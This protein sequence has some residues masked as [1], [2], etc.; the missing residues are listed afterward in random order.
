MDEE[1][2]AKNAIRWAMA[3][4]GSTAYATRCLAFV[5]DAIERS[6]EIEMFGGDDAAESARIYDAAA[7]TGP[8]PLG[9]LVF[10]D[11]VGEMLGERRNWG[12]VGLSLGDGAVIHAWDRVRIDDHVALA[13]I[14][15][16]PG[17]EPLRL[18]GW[19]P[20]R[21][22]LEGSIP[23]TYDSDEDAAATAR[24]QQSARFSG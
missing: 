10:Y 12:H 2:C 3:H 6:N 24:A 1:I 17:W 8:P 18:A 11:S 16:A 23:K 4:L 19:T 21:R 15:P 20:L 13:S 22:A 7:K 5:E 9:A 14:D